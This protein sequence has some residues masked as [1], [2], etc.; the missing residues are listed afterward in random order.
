MAKIL[1]IED[2]ADNAALGKKAV[3]AKEIDF[4]WAKNANEGMKMALELKKGVDILLFT[5]GYKLGKNE[6]E[7]RKNVNRI[8]DLEPKPCECIR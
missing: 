8:L 3:E 5:T 2:I 7:I 1:L 6:E 4:Y